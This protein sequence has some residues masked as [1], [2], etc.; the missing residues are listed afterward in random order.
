MKTSNK[1]TCGH[2]FL[3]R[4]AHSK[5]AAG[6][7]VKTLTS[8]KRKWNCFLVWSIN[9]RLKQKNLSL[10]YF[11]FNG[12]RH[13]MADEVVTLLDWKNKTKTRFCYIKLLP[14]KQLFSHFLVKYGRVLSPFSATVYANETIWAGKI[15]RTFTTL[16]IQSPF[17]IFHVHQ[18]HRVSLHISTYLLLA[19]RSS[20]KH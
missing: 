17:F 9:V 20:V 12:C 5:R 4:W 19:C 3:L 1:S 7:D 6:T 14:L 8:V 11:K 16:I 13:K 10:T 15:T 2:L 18:S